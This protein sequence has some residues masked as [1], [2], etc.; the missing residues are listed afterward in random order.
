MMSESRIIIDKNC[1]KCSYFDRYKLH[2]CGKCILPIPHW[3]V[4]R[5]SRTVESTEGRGCYYFRD[6][7][8]VKSGELADKLNPMVR[9]VKP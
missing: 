8:A 3:A 2:N 7:E 9:E 5:M 1:G 4:A 6:L